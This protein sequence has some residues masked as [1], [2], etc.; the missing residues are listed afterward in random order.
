MA[1][2]T[3]ASLRL[4]LQEQPGS[5]EFSGQFVATRNAVD[6]FGDSVI[7]SALQLVQEQVRLNNGMGYLQVLEIGGVRLWIIDDGAMVTALLPEDY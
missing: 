5:C 4:L 6:R 7:L 2:R 3:E 1:P